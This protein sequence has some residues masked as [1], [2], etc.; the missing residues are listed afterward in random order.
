MRWPTAVHAR[1]LILDFFTAAFS[2]KACTRHNRQHHNHK[3]SYRKHRDNALHLFTSFP[4]LP[5][6]LPQITKP[7]TLGPNNPYVRRPSVPWNLISSDTARW[8]FRQRVY[9]LGSNKDGR[10]MSSVALAVVTFGVCLVTLLVAVFAGEAIHRLVRPHLLDKPSGEGSNSGGGFELG[11]QE[12]SEGA[13]A[14][15]E[16]VGSPAVE[17]YLRRHQLG[18]WGEIDDENRRLNSV[19]LGEGGSLG[20]ESAYK[21]EDGTVLRIFTFE[22][23]SG[24]L[25]LTDEE[26]HRALLSMDKD[27]PQENGSL[28]VRPLRDYLVGEGPP[29]ED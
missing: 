11:E 20:F 26:Y 3:G 24:T 23:C 18:D 13:E 2:S 6:S 4:S 10:G 27:Y 7:A 21:M 15:I 14:L 28:Y 12:V 17:R 25:L 22:D 1:E 9:S 16:R 5:L 29:K 8:I 19:S